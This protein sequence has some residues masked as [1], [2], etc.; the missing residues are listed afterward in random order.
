VGVSLL[1]VLSDHASGAVA[2]TNEYMSNTIDQYREAK[3]AYQ[4]LHNQAKKELIARFNQLTA[5]LFL[6]QKELKDDFGHKVTIPAKGKAVRTVRTVAV[7]TPEP[8]IPN[9]KIAVLEKRIAAEKVKLEKAVAAGK[10][11]K[12]IKDRIYELEDELRLTR[13][14]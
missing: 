13:E 2:S 8:V 1:F 9:P 10:A 6:I 4:K 3:A 5:E 11:D 12:P 14:G 7:K